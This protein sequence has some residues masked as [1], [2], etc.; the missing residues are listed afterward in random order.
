MMRRYLVFLYRTSDFE[1]EIHS[2]VEGE[3][4]WVAR[5]EVANMD[6]AMTCSISYVSLKTDQSLRAFLSGSVL[7]MTLSE[8]F[9]K[10]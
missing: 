7:K 2:T 10:K 3:V 1:G 5:E 9:G 6:L 8:N 4:R